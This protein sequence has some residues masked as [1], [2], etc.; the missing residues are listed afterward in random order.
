MRHV[1]LSVWNC[2][3]VIVVSLISILVCGPA[4]YLWWWL[5]GQAA[6]WCGVVWWWWW[7]Y[8]QDTYFA[9]SK[10]A[11]QLTDCGVTTVLILE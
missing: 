3:I 1:N 6:Y 2:V 10:I 8:G 5:C 7:L 11:S 9:K 4:A